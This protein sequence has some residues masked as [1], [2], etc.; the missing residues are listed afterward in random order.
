[1]ATPVSMKPP[2]EILGAR[3]LQEIE[4]EEGSLELVCHAP[5][6]SP[7]FDSRLSFLISL[8]ITSSSL[9]LTTQHPIIS[10]N[11]LQIKYTY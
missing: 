8:S 7:S 4:R 6:L 9:L 2:A 10:Q 3:L 1:M 11:P 5:S